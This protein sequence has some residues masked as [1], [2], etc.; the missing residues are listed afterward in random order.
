MALKYGATNLDKIRQ[1]FLQR[2]KEQ[3]G[4]KGWWTPD[5]DGS[6]KIRILPP[7]A[8]SEMWFKEYGVHYMPETETRERTAITCPKLTMN[9]PCPICGYVSGLWRTRKDEDIAIAKQIGVKKRACCN[10]VVAG[11]DNEVMVYPFGVQVLDQ[12]LQQQVG[13][14]ESGPCD[15]TDP[16]VGFNITINLTTEMTA[17]GNFPK[18][19]VIVSR[20][21]RPLKD[22][23]VLD[24]LNDLNRLIDGKVQSA[25][26]IKKAVFGV[27]DGDCVTSPANPPVDTSETEEEIVEEDDTSTAPASASPTTPPA[28]TA[29]KL[30]DRLKTWAK[31]KGTP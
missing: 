6:Y 8:G 26:E 17:S 2:Q 25:L 19:T 4:E 23:T 7:V 11:K 27:T 5:K 29:P 16:K 12:L 3:E 18:Y 13:D 9:Q 15:F 31:K 28:S 24:K 14:D 21:S 1:R 10:V 22:M 30:E 20:E